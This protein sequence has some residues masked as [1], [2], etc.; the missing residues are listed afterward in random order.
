MKGVIKVLKNSIMFWKIK[1]IFF[2]QCLFF[3]ISINKQCLLSRLYVHISIAMILLKTLYP[4]GIRTRAFRSRF[5]CAVHC[6]TPP[7]TDVMILKIF[8]PKKLAKNWSF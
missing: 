3:S 6:A 1:K 2:G 8:S 5:G 4:G 7:G